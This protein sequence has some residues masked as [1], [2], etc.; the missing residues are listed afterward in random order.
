MKGCTKARVCLPVT[1]ELPIVHEIDH[2]CHD[3]A[4]CAED[5]NQHGECK[6]DEGYNIHIDGSCKPGE[7]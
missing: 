4:H 1:D 2:Q 6:C 5:S 3:H 7:G